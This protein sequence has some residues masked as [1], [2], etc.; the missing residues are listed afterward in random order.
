MVAAALVG[1]VLIRNGAILLGKRAPTR[2]FYPGVWDVFGG[3]VE[4]HESPEQALVRE[5][6]EEI[7]ITPLAFAE[8]AFMDVAV[9]TVEDAPPEPPQSY[10]YHLYQ[11]TQWEG[12]PQNALVEEHSEIRWV[13]LEDV[14]RLN[15]ASPAYLPIF[16]RLAA[17]D[18]APA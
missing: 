10:K 14:V 2:A 7:A 18:I 5:L 17:A 9:A 6:Q 8:V 12:A 11:V 15:L 16:R 1:A 13:P 3:H 4:P